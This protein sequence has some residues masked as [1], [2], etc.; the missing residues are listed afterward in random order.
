MTT[1][2]T[3]NAMDVLKIVL[4]IA[5]ELGASKWKMAFCTALGQQPRYREVPA[6]DLAAVQREIDRARARFGLPAET[7]VA[8]CYEAGV[9]G[10]G[11]IGRSSRWASRTSSSTRRASK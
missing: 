11:C 4:C 1:A 7:R 6:R 10:S 5:F 9:T 2:T 8:S 3:P